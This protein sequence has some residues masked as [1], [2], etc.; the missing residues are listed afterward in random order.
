MS[1]RLVA[2]LFGV[3]I[4][5]SI[6]GATATAA[7]DPHPVAGVYAMS[8]GRL[9]ASAAALAGLIGVAVGGLALRS[10]GRVGTGPGRRGAFA[11]LVAGLIG[12]ALGGLLARHYSIAG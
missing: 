5:I 9:T 11:A 6:G 3:S 8:A 10:A 7:D 2:I 4:A 12:T 1:N